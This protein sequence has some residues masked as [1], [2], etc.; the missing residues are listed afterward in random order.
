[1]AT[2]AQ[3]LYRLRVDRNNKFWFIKYFD[4]REKAE[5]YMAHHKEHG[6]Q[7]PCGV[8]EIKLSLDPGTM[9]SALEY[10][11]LEETRIMISKIKAEWS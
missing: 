8:I 9:A 5:E 6:D 7:Y 3:R 2:E 1:M 11:A 4:A 10:A